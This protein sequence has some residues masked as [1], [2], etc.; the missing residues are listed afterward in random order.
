[1]DFT[2]YTHPIDGR[3]YVRV[4]RVLDVLHDEGLAEWREIVGK[5]EA[6]ERVDS[7]ADWGREIH[8]IT[9]AMDMNQPFTLTDRCMVM[10]LRYTSWR[11]DFVTQFLSIE[12]TYFSK[13][14]GF[15]CTIDR[16]ALLKHSSFPQ[17][18]DLKSGRINKKKFALQMGAYRTA[19]EENG[20][21]TRDPIILP[22]DKNYD[23]VEIPLRPI[24]VED[25]GERD[26]FLNL[27]SVYRYMTGERWQ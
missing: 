7:A 18:I 22:L 26:V 9:R 21:R 20:I 12:K 11:D 8:E 25:N 17:I 14:H 16:I 27:L 15:A 3:K 23:Q 24:T 1:M 10:A 2:H 5:R 19:A 6:D 13:K 4:S